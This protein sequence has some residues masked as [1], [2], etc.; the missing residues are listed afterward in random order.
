MKIKQYNIID[1]QSKQSTIPHIEIQGAYWEW[2]V[3]VEHT[4]KAS[5]VT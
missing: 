4:S 1:K 5:E 3:G 2:G